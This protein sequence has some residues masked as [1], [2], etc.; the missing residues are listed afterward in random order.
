[1]PSDPDPAL[2][3][4][5]IAAILIVAPRTVS[6]MIDTG[7]LPGYRLPGSKTRRVLRSELVA[8]CEAQHL[9]ESIRLRAI[10]AERHYSGRPRT[11]CPCAGRCQ[12]E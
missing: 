3:T 10:A 4:A 6:K 2:G 7:V 11:A 9:P 8:F 1:M 12:D 5:A